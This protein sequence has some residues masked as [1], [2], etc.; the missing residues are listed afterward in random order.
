VEVQ[1]RLAPF[2][3]ELRDRLGQ[4]RSEGERL[5]MVEAALAAR[6]ARG[7]GVDPRVAEATRRLA[8]GGEG[9]SV[10]GLADQLGV[11]HKHLIDLFRRQVGVG[12]KM[13]GRILRLQRVLGALE[14]PGA[15]RLTDLAYS[16][17]YADQA[18]LSSEFRALT[19]IAPSAYGRTRT[20]DPNHLSTDALRAG[21]RRAG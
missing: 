12:P 16:C 13:L 2:C 11:S 3:L 4:A 21:A 6:L 19:G 9:L 18:H 5:P 1:G 7:P 17:G 8:A 20:V 14:R 10:A 15:A